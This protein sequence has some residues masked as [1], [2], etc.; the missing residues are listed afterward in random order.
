MY[1]IL[2]TSLIAL[3][4]TVA[5]IGTITQSAYASSA[6]FN[7][8]RR[9]ANADFRAGQDD[10]SCS[11]DNSHGYC[12]DYKEGYAWEMNALRYLH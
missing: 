12:I 9:Q 6:A 4:L 8:G 2:T 5:A 3:A 10:W 1:K 11:I 7:D